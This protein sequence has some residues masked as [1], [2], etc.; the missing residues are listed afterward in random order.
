MT[1]VPPSHS[2]S[3]GFVAQT[4]LTTVQDSGS[5]PREE[6]REGWS[7]GR[8]GEDEREANEKEQEQQ[9]GISQR[10]S[11]LPSPPLTRNN[12]A[13]SSR[14]AAAGEK[15]AGDNKE[16][17]D[18]DNG[19]VDETDI[20]EVGRP[21]FEDPLRHPSLVVPSQDS[22]LD[23]NGRLR[24]PTSN[25]PHPISTNIARPA[26]SSPQPWDLVDPPPDNGQNLPDP[27]GTVKSKFS[28]MPESARGRTLIPKSSYYFGPPPAGSA[29]G[30]Q[31]IGQIGVHHPRE[32][33]RVERDYSGGELIQ[34][35]PIYPLE[36]EGRISPTQFLET[37]NAIN[38]RLISAHSLRWS[39]LDNFLAVFTLQLSRL[40]VTTHYEKEMKLLEQL[41]RDLNAE[42]Y[43]PV[44]LNLLWPRKVAFLFL[45]IEYY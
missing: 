9:I 8:A 22:L 15:L 28:R 6:E 30:T 11:I 42:V 26:A 34:F 13:S 20:I 18:T 31:P 41:F 2:V 43:N 27:H 39:A 4:H 3:D 29:Y 45:E 21:T 24:M 12:S 44:G 5:R 23:A 37:I 7:V 32:V 17:N 19:N 1:S 16:K 38:E 40:L 14:V 10:G 25:S 33:L 35:A 36:L